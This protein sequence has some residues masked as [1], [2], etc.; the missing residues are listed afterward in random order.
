MYAKFE[1]EKLIF[2]PQNKDDNI[3]N[4]CNDKAL[5]EA[6]GFEDVPDEQIAIYNRGYGYKFEHNPLQIIDISETEEYLN[7]VLEVEKEA[8]NK[9]FIKTSIGYLK[10]NTAVGD[11]LS[12][13]NT[14]A[15]DVMRKNIFPPNILL[16]YQVDKSSA[17]NIEMD[18]DTFFDLY[19]EVKAG[20]L[21]RF[22]NK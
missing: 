4:Y 22:N 13:F 19:D 6:D 2:P 20:Y 5:V 16:I 17:W 10:I 1:N 9:E 7:Q 14:Y 21:T 18:A 11:L 15:I 8:L 12:I 3:L